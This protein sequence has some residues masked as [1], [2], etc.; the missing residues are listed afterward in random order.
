MAI[1]VIIL[2]TDLWHYCVIDRHP[3]V[4]LAIANLTGNC[5]KESYKIS[6]IDTVQSQK[7][8]DS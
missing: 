7:W 4:K 6:Y 1:A 8:L 5:C 2:L 3:L